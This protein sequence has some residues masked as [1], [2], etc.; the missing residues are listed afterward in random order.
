VKGHVHRRGSSWAYVVDVAPDPA[1]GKRRQKTQGG[2]STKAA[3]SK[4]MRTFLVE[5]ESGRGVGRNRIQLGEYLERWLET[6]KGDLRPS[7]WDAYAND[8]AKLTEKIGAVQ[9]Q[10]LTPLQIEKVYAELMVDGGRYGR[11]LSPKTIRNVHA[12][13]RRALSDAE[14]LGLIVSNPARAAHPPRADRKELATWSAD[15]LGRFLEAVESDRM[16][17]AY[18][19]LGTTGM[20]RGEVLGLRWTDIDLDGGNLSVEQTLTAPNRQLILGPPKTAKSRRRIALDPRSIDA[21]RRHKRRQNE[22]RLQM[23][24]LWRNDADLVFCR[25]DGSLVHPDRFTREFKRQ[26]E[27]AGLPELRGP[28]A[29]R[30]TWATL[31]LQSGIHPKVVSDRLGHSTI[32]ITLDTYSH[33]VPGLDDD[34]ANVVADRIF[35]AGS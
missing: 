12:V 6:V 7:T 25:E 4:A 18:V 2:F 21:L 28:H 27:A 16:H 26:V 33:V 15:E 13:L 5:H 17:A 10:E 3:A 19:L 29:L 24:E 14:R 1:K 31:A 22:E 23:G 20:R 32:H 11:P 35:G 34:A 8:A 9:I 30:H